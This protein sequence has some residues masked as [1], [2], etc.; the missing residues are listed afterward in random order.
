[1]LKLMTW[2]SGIVDYRTA[3]EILEHVGQI[4]ASDSSIRRQAQ[5]WGTEF[6]SL[7]EEERIRANILPGRWGGPYKASAPKG[8]MGVAMDGGMIHMSQATLFERR[9]AELNG[10]RQRQKEALAGL[11]TRSIS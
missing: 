7:A 1:M 2:L 8:R 6:Q 9:L 4:P 11:R 5:Q 3:E 10:V